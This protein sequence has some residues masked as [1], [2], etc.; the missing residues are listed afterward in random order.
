MDQIMDQAMVQITVLTMVRVMVAVVDEVAV[1]VI[2]LVV[3]VSIPAVHQEVV[4][5][6]DGE[7]LVLDHPQVRN[8]NKTEI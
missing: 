2:I 3:R 6:L 8:Q 5:T 1:Q 4:Q 7:I